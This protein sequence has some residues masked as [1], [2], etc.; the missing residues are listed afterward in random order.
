MTTEIATMPKSRNNSHSLH[1]VVS[2]VACKTKAVTT[3][4]Q[5]PVCE[6]HWKQYEAE[7][8]RYLP[9]PERKVYRML[10]DCYKAA[11]AGT[12]PRRAENEGHQK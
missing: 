9:L 6:E 8:K 5:I 7:A 11:N 2:C 10:F 4:A 1:A 3:A 12:E